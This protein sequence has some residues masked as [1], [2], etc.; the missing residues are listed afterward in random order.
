M[1][2]AFS[3]TFV[4][5]SWLFALQKKSAALFKGIGS[6]TKFLSKVIAIYGQQGP[7]MY[8]CFIPGARSESTPVRALTG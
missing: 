1:C 2:L 7:C 6:R 3:L 5:Q 8:R 4:R